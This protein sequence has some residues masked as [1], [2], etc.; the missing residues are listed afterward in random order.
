MASFALKMDKKKINR[1]LLPSTLL[2]KFMTLSHTLVLGMVV[3]VV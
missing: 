1:H 3:R 2:I